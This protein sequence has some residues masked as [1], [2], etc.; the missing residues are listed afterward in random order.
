MS[1]ATICARLVAG[2]DAESAV[3]DAARQV[4]AV[5]G[6]PADLVVMFVHPTMCADPETLRDEIMRT[7]A[8]RH[9]IGCTGET[10]IGTGQEIEGAPAIV[11]WGALLPGAHITDLR[12]SAWPMP[13]GTI[14][15]AGWPT[16]AAAATED[17][18][19]PG[20]DDVAIVLAD[21]FSLPIDQLLSHT[22]M[23]GWQPQLV[24]GLASGGTRPGEHTLFRNE[25]IATDG[26][27]GVSIG[28]FPVTT[29]VSQGC[30][31]IGPEMVVTD[32]D[33]FGR[34]HQLAG[35]PA[36]TKLQE[37]LDQLDDDDLA[38][39]QTGLTL[40]IVINENQP[41]Y[42]R[43][44]YLMRGL[45]GAHPDTGDLHVGEHVRIGQT[46]RVHVRDAASADIDLHD[47]LSD[48]RAQIV[49]APIG[50]LV[51]S[52]NGRGMNMFDTPHHDATVI[53]EELDNPPLA[54]LF[55]NGEIGPVGGRNFIHGFTATIAIFGS[56][57]T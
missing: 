47:T 20:P 37:V 9:F 43:G 19:L 23:S 28:G 54:G 8:P 35:Q 22:N 11:V 33:G 45:L 16:S 34:L 15:I 40:G 55:C 12:A 7:L 18:Q 32:T 52:C 10:I 56:L 14:E 3:A 26:L 29:A 31:P 48:A 50:A 51:F 30:S 53:A 1:G 6:Q 38:L 24:G 49:G 21:P 25:L 5:L 46:L 17:T 44:D 2:L 36:L 42:G 57:E 27:V 4:A 13:D 41:E 39:A